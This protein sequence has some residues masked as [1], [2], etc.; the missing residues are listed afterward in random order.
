[1][2]REKTKWRRDRA[3]RRK[4]SRE[5]LRESEELFRSTFENAAVGIAHVTTDG[6]WLRVNDKLCQ[7]LGYSREQLLAKTFQ[8]VTHPDDVDTNLEFLNR[9]LTGEIQ[10]YAL[11]KRYLHNDGSIVWSNLTVSLI[12]NRR[13]NKPLYFISV[14]EDITGR[15]QAEE[16]SR[17]SEARLRLVVEGA[18][19]V[20]WDVDVK[21]D[22][23][24]WN[25]RHYQILGYPPNLTTPTWQMWRARVH[26]EDVDYVMAARATALESRGLYFP[27]HRIIRADD[28]EIRWVAPFARFIYDEQ[29]QAIRFVGVDFDITERKR[30]EQALRQ[31]E[32]RYRTLVET[33][34]SVI[35]G[36][37]TDYRIFEWNRAAERIFGWPREEALGKNYL[38]T[39]LSEDARQMV[40]AEIHRVLGG[41]PTDAYENA[42]VHRDGSR[43]TLLW[44]VCNLLDGHGA[45]IGILA[46]GQDITE[47]KRAEE[48]LR[49]SEERLRL[50]LDGGSL[51]TW[52]HDMVT[53]EIIRDRRAAAIIGLPS[54]ISHGESVFINVVHPDDRDKL[55]AARHRAIAEQRE[56]V[57]EF[58]V[59]RPD[60]SIVWVLNR[61][62]P[63]YNESGDIVR[64]SGICVDITERKLAEDALQRTYQELEQR[65]DE[66]T[67]EL[68]FTQAQ[69]RALAGRLHVLQEEERS[70][71]ARELHDEFGAAFTALKVD[72]HWIMARLPKHSDVLEEKARQ[73]SDLIDN[74][75]DSVRRTAG[76]L[77][78]RLLDDFGLVAAIE[79]QIEEFQRR[80]EIQC[81]TS[82]PEEVE[83]DRAISTAVFRIVQEALTNVARHA[84]AT[85]VRIGLR[86]E[87]DRVWIEIRDNGKGIDFDVNSNDT[88]LGL[89]GMQERAYAFGGHV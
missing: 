38:T 40:D 76:L 32:E 1:M 3:K 47:R 58:R 27:E 64:L 51:G 26:P 53:G 6:H 82:F 23:A 39:F 31:S 78:P 56:Y 36:L 62:K 11:E 42:V 69:L 29:G 57:S 63:F 24:V 10:T 17:E 5:A 16:Q 45:A 35:L 20:T 8:E 59:Q 68:I 34:S 25:E 86:V 21:S 88:S 66:R 72:L 46:V 70:Q 44:N 74:S 54:G 33:G 73:M 65:V 61:S 43:R 15:K 30:A 48:A 87:S 55:V 79:W 85:E 19:M 60:G 41:H 7:I 13:T 89:F 84:K 83:I 12:R 49:E 52:H 80:T 18:G 9:A 71:L 14:I 37:T 77:R 4:H 28:G 75:V 81:V 2:A 67:T 50:A 22:T